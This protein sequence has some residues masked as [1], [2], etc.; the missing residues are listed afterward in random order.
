MEDDTDRSMF[1]VDVHLMMFSSS[2]LLVFQRAG[3]KRVNLIVI[4][5]YHAFCS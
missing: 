2:D 1:V 3:Y 5:L 4:I